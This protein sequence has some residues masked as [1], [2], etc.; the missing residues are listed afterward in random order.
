[1]TFFLGASSSMEVTLIIDSIAW[2]FGQYLSTLCCL[3]VLLSERNSLS[4]GYVTTTFE[5]TGV[6]ETDESPAM[7]SL[8]YSGKL[9][10]I[11]SRVSSLIT[12]NVEAWKVPNSAVV[13][14]N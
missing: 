3:L 12:S 11:I 13:F 7:F 1:V 5:V 9:S 2:A 10:F 6:K 14:E 4:G 8:I